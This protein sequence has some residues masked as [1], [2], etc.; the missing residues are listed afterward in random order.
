[1][2]AT[3]DRPPVYTVSERPLSRDDEAQGVDGRWF[4]RLA[5]APVFSEGTFVAHLRAGPGRWG[6]PA[7]FVCGKDGEGPCGHV[8]AVKRYQAAAGR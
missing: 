6:A 2:T 4:V 1:M 3:G 5:G 8:E 7:R